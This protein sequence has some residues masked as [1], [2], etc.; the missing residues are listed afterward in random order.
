MAVP[1]IITPGQVRKTVEDCGL[2]QRYIH[3]AYAMFLSREEFNV[4][5]GE[6]ASTSDFNKLRSEVANRYYGGEA[7]LI[8]DTVMSIGVPL[9][10]SSDP[11]NGGSDSSD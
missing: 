9:D 10:G 7:D 11:G 1:S 8:D 6:S 3:Y 2:N 5:V 4:L